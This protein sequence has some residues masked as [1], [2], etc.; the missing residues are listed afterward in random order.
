LAIALLRL[1]TA[2]ATILS[3]DKQEV[4]LH[5]YPPDATARLDGKQDLSGNAVVPLSRDTQHYID[6]SKDGYESRR[7]MI[8]QTLNPLF[9]LNLALLPLFWVGMAVDAMTGHINE[10][11]PTDVTANL[12]AKGASPEQPAVAQKP[13]SSGTSGSSS[14]VAFEVKPGGPSVDPLAG[15]P[16]TTMQKTAQPAGPAIDGPTASKTAGPVTSTSKAAPER[17]HVPRTMVSGAQ[18]DWVIAVMPAGTTGK[19][20]FDKNTLIALTDQIRVFLAERGARVVDRSQ[21]EAALKG[22]V[23]DEKKR[24]YS[25]CVDSSCQIPLGKALAASHILRSTV[26]RFGK[27]CATNGE[28]IDLR[29][30]VTVAA[31]SAKSDCSEEALLYAAE[32]LAEQLISGSAKPK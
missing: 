26:A 30:E 13:P 24:S 28:M 27:A 22:L 2:C 21:Q 29:A 17:Q 10:L 8:K 7:V 25:A 18:K 9:F 23:D 16:S 12:S 1:S 20:T 6:F 32:S 15:S 19:T 3:P 11:E 5:A 4:K 31:G 14:S